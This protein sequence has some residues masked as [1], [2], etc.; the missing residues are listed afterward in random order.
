MN[1]EHAYA[2][3]TEFVKNDNLIKHMLSVE[4]AMR[5]YAVKYGDDPDYWALAG[6]LHDFDW[7][8]HPTLEQHP[9][10]GA[11][12]LRARGVPE[13][14][15]RCIQSHAPHTGIPREKVM[16]K[17]LF[18]VDELTGLV[19]ACALVR[20]SKSLHDLTAKS[21]KGKWKDKAFAAG[22]NRADIE[23]G[24][25]ELGVD[26]TEHITFTIESMRVIAPQLGLDGV[27]AAQ[28]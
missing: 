20:P 14:I 22:V 19:T 2:I 6:L 27:L 21:V 18:A 15:I 9:Q 25:Q 12:I 4:A 8:V 3:V 16:D 24:A 13:D 5:G 23:R 7:E 26:L 17:A 11:A 10:A 28:T 1:R